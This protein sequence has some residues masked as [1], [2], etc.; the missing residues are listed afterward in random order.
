MG[1][2]GATF[3]EKIHACK[4][5]VRKIRLSPSIFL[6]HA[7][8]LEIGNNKYPIRRAICKTFTVPR[9]NLDVSQENLFSGQLLTCIVIG[10]VDNN[11]SNGAFHKNPFNFKH[12][13]L[14]QLKI[15]LVGNNNRWNQS[16]QT[17]PTSI[18]WLI[19]RY[20]LELENSRKTR[21]STLLGR[22][23]VTGRDGL[24]TFWV[25]TETKT[26]T[27]ALETETRPRRL[28][29]CLRRDPRVSETRPRR[30][31]FLVET[32][33]RHMAYKCMVYALHTVSQKRIP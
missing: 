14:T 10:W 27:W 18:Y 31:L 23:I 12:F 6:A 22:I 30:D 16:N 33:S 8:A 2:E 4:L 26:E 7:K 5:I 21:V 9:G 20:F 25:E 1:A 17:L 32:I 13:N 15:Y 28:P 11:S 19:L 29:N 3:K 24:K